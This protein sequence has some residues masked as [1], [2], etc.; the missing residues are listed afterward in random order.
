MKYSGWVAG[1]FAILSGMVTLTLP[2]SV[3]AADGD[4]ILFRDVQT[5]AAIRSPVVPD[6]N[7]RI[8]N[9][10]PS[11]HVGEDLQM[12][13]IPGELD[14]GDFAAV[15]SG[16][17][18][19]LQLLAPTVQGAHSG[20]SGLVNHSSVAGTGPGHAGGALGNIDGQVNRSIEQGLR[21]LQILQRP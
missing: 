8:I 4:I 19:T 18:L 17:R 13:S 20:A 1:W 3:L 10:K 14:D 11:T 9:P 15:T 7:P 16:S 5:R 6:P 21:P 2:G 12:R